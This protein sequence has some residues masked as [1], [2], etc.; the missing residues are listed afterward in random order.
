MF[1]YATLCCKKQNI[2]YKEKHKVC[3][4]HMSRN[5]RFVSP[6]VTD[7]P[8]GEEEAGMAQRFQLQRMHQFAGIYNA[9]T[10]LWVAL[11]LSE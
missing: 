9:C 8:M 11:G 10:T 5:K 1:S 2:K 4:R 7:R 3:Q 6:L